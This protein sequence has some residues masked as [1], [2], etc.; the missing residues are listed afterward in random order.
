MWF[1]SLFDAQLARSPRT[2]VSRIRRGPRVRPLLDVLEDR[3]LLSTYVVNTLT[4]T[5]AGSGLA[6]DLRYC[7]TNATSGND[8]ITFA[9]SLTGTIKLQS[10]L[11]NLTAS[12]AIQGPGSGNITLQASNSSIALLYVLSKANVQ[13]SGLTIIDS[14]YAI[15][16]DGT[17]A[18]DNCT[19]ANNSNAIFNYGSASVTDDTISGSTNGEGAIV[20]ESGSLSV[21]GSTLS[22]NNASA[23]F[24]VL[25]NYG[26]ATVSSSTFSG[27][28]GSAIGNEQGNL[29]VTNSTL[30]N[31]D[32]V[33][34]NAVAGTGVTSGPYGGAPGSSAGNGMGGGIYIGG[35][36]LT[37]DSSTLE[38][39]YA[40]GG[41]TAGLGA[42]G[43]AAGNG[44]GGGLYIGAGTVTI[45]NSTLGD[46]EAI[47]G[48]V[49][50]SPGA[51]GAAGGGIYNAA[52]ASA[53]QMYDTIL[54]GDT[55]LADGSAAHAASDLSGSLTSLGHNLIGNTT[56]GSGFA[57][58]DLVNVNPL[59]GPLQNN[60]GPTQTMALLPGSPAINAGDNS[61]APAY[62][63]RGPGYP[64]IVGGT[65]DIGAFEVQNS[66]A[67]AVS[68]FPATSKAGTAGS[69]T[70]TAKNAD[71]TM[72]TGYTGTI[73]FTSTDLQAV[74]PSDYT[75]TA[76]DNGTHTFTATLKTAGAQSLISTDTSS[77]TGREGGI[78]VSPAA[79]STMS[80]A[81]FPS[82]STA[83][84]AGSFTVTLKDP[85]GNIATGYTGT[86]H[87][88]SSDG[89]AAL[90]ANYT[91][92]AADAGVHSFSA[93]LKT[94]GT[95]SITVTDTTTA[96]L[97]G[98]ETGITVN[99]AAASRFIL[100][101]PSRVSAGVRFSLTLTVEDAYGNVVT[102][103]TGTVHFT[104]TEKTATLP[105]NYTFTAAD[106]GVHTFTG[107]V[108][109]Q[110]GYEK[111]TLTDTRTSSLSASVIVEVL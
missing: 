90:P 93:T 6:G 13:I 99:P 38:G 3:T 62:D 108:L 33:G 18:V 68:G 76:A 35:G 51:G 81:G 91:F 56:G 16:N 47:G 7:I 27:N 10:D 15:V 60:G 42:Y 37:L 102:N 83:G 64:R 53:L 40:V 5:G 31:N 100:T 43:L 95:Q 67:L 75:F 69:F 30:S 98:S 22:A 61:G 63:Q 39:N 74:L 14:D 48:S 1:R 77:L 4:D 17:V 28:S 94:A 54:S 72:D 46:N 20:N 25:T 73:H 107:L 24:G 71:G 41:S 106:K 109:R 26:T 57:A 66:L 65:I 59:L 49:N 44:Y 12:V 52:G 97:T 88:T 34:S 2:P 86:V 80:V 101:A 19:F 84:A 79:A 21:T 89:K 55:I 105:S 78:T 29:T 8:T 58:S 104:S 111:I 110:K 70:V 32:A 96:S 82:P 87:V 85:Y 36:T 9:P 103:Y 23:Q 92:I 11:P 50:Y 45:N